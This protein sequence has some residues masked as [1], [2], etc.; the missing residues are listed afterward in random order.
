MTGE[1]HSSAVSELSGSAKLLFHESCSKAGTRTPGLACLGLGG[2]CVLR[3]GSSG[4][5]VARLSAGSIART[6]SQ[7]TQ[8]DFSG[9]HR[10][11]Y[12]TECI[13]VAANTAQAAPLVCTQSIN[14]CIF[15]AG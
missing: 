13:S 6:P 10:H 12:Q 9:H 4:N 1:D 15:K 3:S 2:R 11:P 8:R 5:A 14:L 7:I